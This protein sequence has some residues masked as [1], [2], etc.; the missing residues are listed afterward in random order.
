MYYKEYSF[1]DPLLTEA[2]TNLQIA[3]NQFDNAITPAMVDIA[4]YELLAAEMH[5][6]AVLKKVRSDEN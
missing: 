5:L 3:Q 4:I 1:I 2:F 6:K